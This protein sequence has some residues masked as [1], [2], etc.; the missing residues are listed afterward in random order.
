M[1]GHYVCMLAVDQQCKASAASTSVMQALQ[2]NLLFIGSLPGCSLLG[3]AATCILAA[4]FLL[5]RLLGC[6]LGVSFPLLGVLLRLLGRLWRQRRQSRQIDN[7]S[8]SDAASEL[9]M[10]QCQRWLIGRCRLKRALSA[11]RR[12]ESAAGS[13]QQTID[14]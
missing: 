10:K 1:L 11:G 13:C 9:G 3:V 5:C 12:Q 2:A 4:G 6:M 8:S 7:C 14:G